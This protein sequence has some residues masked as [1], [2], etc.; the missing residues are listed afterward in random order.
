MY[1]NNH[2]K[3]IRYNKR[4]FALLFAVMTASVL[5]TIGLSIFNISLKELLLS[6]ASRDSQIAFYAA[7]SARE[8]A[9]YWDIKQSAFST[10]LTES[11][12]GDGVLVGAN[13]IVCGNEEI[14]LTITNNDSNIYITTGN[15]LYS[16]KQEYLETIPEA[17]FVVTKEYVDLKG[18]IN[19]TISTLGH[20]AEI[21]ERR[22]ER[23][24]LQT[25]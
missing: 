3:I 12:T 11:C 23:G 13:Q 4:G 21:D 8:C 10:C 25:Y 17:N 18:D 7:D 1:K 24:I 20:N 9:L 5:L 15:F 16:E 19:T 2:T 14:D 22:L 6:T